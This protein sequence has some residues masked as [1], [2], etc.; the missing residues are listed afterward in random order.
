MPGSPLKP[1]IGAAREFRPSGSEVRRRTRIYLPIEVAVVGFGVVRILA[2]VASTSGRIAALALGFLVIA[3][4]TIL[5]VAYVRHTR[6]VI[7]ETQVHYIGL[8]RTR[9]IP[10]AAISR[11]IRWSDTTFGNRESDRV[12]LLVSGREKPAFVL[13]GALWGS[14]TLDAI[15][16]A[17]AVPME[18]FANSK[19]AAA[20]HRSAVA[21]R[22]RH[23]IGVVWLIVG[24]VLLVA[25][26]VS[27]PGSVS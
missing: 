9:C 26:I 13:D 1:E 11:V 12:T 23:P 14:A 21:W 8:L 6:L 22:D 7:G 18:T 4:T 16:S 24:A 3:G 17:L 10:R 27:L 19:E 20:R 25:A 2:I 15:P 5:T